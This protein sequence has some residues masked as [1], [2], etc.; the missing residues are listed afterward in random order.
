[1]GITFTAAQA[2]KIATATTSMLESAARL[3]AEVVRNDE[4]AFGFH[5]PV[6]SGQP[7]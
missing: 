7:K 1:M 3:R 6:S 4:P 2:E 5:P